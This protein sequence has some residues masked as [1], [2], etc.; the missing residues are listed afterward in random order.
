MRRLR[1]AFGIA[2]ALQW[3]A[4]RRELVL[5]IS[6]QAL[7]AAVLAV[8]LVFIHNLL[9]LLSRSDR[10]SF[11]AFWPTIAGI[12]AC[13]IARSISRPFV[14]EQQ[15]VMSELV[16][17]DI[18]GRVLAAAS[19]A[20][21]EDF[22]DPAF[23]DRL[24]RVRNE[25]YQNA[26]GLVWSFVNLA[27]QVLVSVSMIVVLASIAPA[28]L[29]IGA[30]GLLPF[31]WSNRRRNR[32][33]YDLTIEQ[34]APLREREYLEDLLTTRASVPELRSLAL[35][36]HL[37]GRVRSLHD[38]RVVATRS[39]AR[40]RFK[41]TLASSLVSSV[42][43]AAALV[44]LVAVAVN[45]DLTV[46][47]AGVAVLALQQVTGQLRGIVD[48]FG[49]LDAAAPFLDDFDRFEREDL[50][51]LQAA[52][53]HSDLPLPPLEA[54]AFDD[55]S[56]T[57]PGTE[58]EV[59]H[60]LSVTVKAGEVVAVVGENGSGKTTVA[61]LVA[62]LYEPT[63]GRIMWNGADRTGF[64]RD[65][66]RRSVALVF[67]DFGRYELTAHENVAFGDVG[68]L[69]DAAGVKS[70]AVRSGAD[71]FLSEL[72]KEYETL[73]SRSFEE[74]VELSGGQ[75]QRVAIAR[76]FFR[77]SPVLVLDEPTAALD[78][79]AEHEL[80]ERLRDL[81]VGR[82]VILISHRFSTV[83]SAD[84][85]LV[86]DEGRLIEEGTHDALMAARG[87]YAEM[88]TIQ[89]SPYSDR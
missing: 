41:V 85:I 2:L 67:Q 16:Q 26:W 35:G 59:L 21:V 28:V 62:G 18:L 69:D 44:V 17:R 79:L 70:A 39:V 83:R 72:P 58:H 84:R 48:V 66:V 80:F 1:R 60:G 34:T 11:S 19:R 37:V 42:L 15:W 25:T 46:A 33:L 20:D 86:L 49:Q 24:N 56:F 50:P 38:R 73:L 4:A 22:E 14:S 9:D 78:P 51:R 27:S 7:D 54:L 5:V 76:A 3:R 75:W 6:T 61:K 64:D 88:F 82:T 65:V 71:E 31:V 53:E 45:G 87:H 81:A 8:Q 29:L 23:H 13:Y 30:L 12:T 55:V 74:G 68:R 40:R 47:S 36:N 52:T 63:S 77:D 32:L 57:Y 10:P 43:A 89:A